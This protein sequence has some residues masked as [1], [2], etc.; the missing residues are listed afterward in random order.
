MNPIAQT[1]RLRKSTITHVYL[2]VINGWDGIKKKVNYK[3]LNKI[4]NANALDGTNDNTLFVGEDS[5]LKDAVDVKLGG[6]DC[7]EEQFN[8]FNNDSTC[9][10]IFLQKTSLI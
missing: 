9:N 6:N 3:S 8:S 5:G 1:G 10:D 4:G 7:E 2:W